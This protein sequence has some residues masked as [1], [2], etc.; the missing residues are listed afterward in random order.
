LEAI[1]ELRASVPDLVAKFRSENKLDEINK[2]KQFSDQR[3]RTSRSP[4][5]PLNQYVE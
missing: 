4:L 1:E 3:T 2:G 5:M